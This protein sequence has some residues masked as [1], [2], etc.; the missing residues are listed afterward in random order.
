MS[1]V[2]EKS[3]RS[4]CFICVFC[5]FPVTSSV[6]KK[7]LDF[8]TSFPHIFILIKS[9]YCNTLS[10]CLKLC[11]IT[12]FHSFFKLQFWASNW[13]L[14][15]FEFFCV[16]V[17]HVYKRRKWD[18]NILFFFFFHFKNERIVVFNVVPI[19]AA[20]Q[21]DPVIHLHSLS[22]I[23]FHYGLSQRDWI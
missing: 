19:S 8:P 12:S 16:L 14:S 4:C 3:P 17:F 2:R 15:T 18:R 22:C 6:T 13:V 7:P 11:F 5:Y 1:Q 10:S 20:Q 23:I 9:I 21:S